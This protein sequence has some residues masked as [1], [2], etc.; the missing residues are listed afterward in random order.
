MKKLIPIVTESKSTTLDQVLYGQFA[1]AAC[2]DLSLIKPLKSD[3]KAIA[4]AKNK[5]YNRTTSVARN[6]HN[7]D[8]PLPMNQSQAPLKIANGL[9]PI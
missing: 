7:K 4:L 3:A 9:Y 1:M 8:A 2:H 5:A 6:F